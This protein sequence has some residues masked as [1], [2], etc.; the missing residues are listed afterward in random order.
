MLA[1]WVTLQKFH[2]YGREFNSESTGWTIDS[3]WNFLGKPMGWIWN[4]SVNSDK[5]LLP[6]LP[7]MKPIP[8]DSSIQ[9]SKKQLLALTRTKRDLPLKILFFFFH[10]VPLSSVNVRKVQV[11]CVCRQAQ[12]KH[13][14]APGFWFHKITRGHVT[15][16]TMAIF[17]YVT[18]RKLDFPAKTR[19][20]ITIFQQKAYQEEKKPT[21]FCSIIT[22][23]FCWF[24]VSIKVSLNPSALP[25][26]AKSTAI[27]FNA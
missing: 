6:F 10:Q 19:K 21:N 24:F 23:F 5:Q 22:I 14:W 16:G 20:K 2:S 13:S 27:G 26:L 11:L 1:V 8:L 7:A 3:T 18:V 17:Q 15:N 25:I 4:W 12:S 9:P